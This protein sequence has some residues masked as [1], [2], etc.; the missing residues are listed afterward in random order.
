MT[1]IREDHDQQIASANAERGLARAKDVLERM[2]F[3]RRLKRYDLTGKTILKTYLFGDTFVLMMDTGYYFAVKI[4]NNYGEYNS[5]A[6]FTI[7]P[8]LALQLGVVTDAEFAEYLDLKNARQT[9]NKN[10]RDA[11]AIRKLIREV[12][13]DKIREALGS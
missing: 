12:G 5:L 10:T 6:T 3:D 2:I 8:E 11:F 13:A 4:D 7:S 9:L 1:T